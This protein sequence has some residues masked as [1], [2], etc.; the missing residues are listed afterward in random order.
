MMK[1]YSVKYLLIILLFSFGTFAEPIEMDN[2]PIREF[3]SW[4]AKKAGRAIIVSPDV[5]GTITVY[6]A[7]VSKDELNGF[8]VSVLRANGFDLSS[9]NP[10]VVGKYSQDY[11]YA[12]S[13]TQD[14][15][16]YDD[17]NTPTGSFFNEKTPSNLI[18]QTYRINNVRAQ[19]LAPVV[20]IYV[21]SSNVAGVKVFPFDGANTL[22]VTA[23]ATQHAELKAFLPDVDVPR[24]QVLIESLMFETTDGDSF[25]F[26]FA[27]GNSSGGSVAGGVN[28]DRLS[29][30]LSSAGGSFGIFNGNVLGLSLK[31]VQNDAHASVLSTP[32]ILTMSGQKGSISVGQNVPFVTG[33]VTGEAASVNNPFQTIERHDVGVSLTVT[34]VVTSTGV[35]IMNI[36][37]RADSISNLKTASDI[38]TNQRQIETTV[39]IKSGQ[40]LLLGGLIDDRSSK[41][42]SS[43]PFISK[44]PLIGW[45][46]TSTSE[47]TEKRTMYVLLR[48]RVLHAL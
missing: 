44:V 26:S 41:D 24:D 4:Y 33:T 22:V 27:A 30:V 36:R 3:V 2:T 35:I 46:F 31:A 13:F 17:N 37:T 10:S 18:T 8:F 47:S 45:L 38:I 7:N 19:D 20:D 11:E 5:S 40:T 48:A 25:D 23:S 43:V 16:S 34:P 21:K 12:D 42:D 28:T 39:H 29:S 9:G 1:P 14:N 6:S 32:R 15:V